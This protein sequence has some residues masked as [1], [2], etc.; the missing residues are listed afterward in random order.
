MASAAAFE[1]AL[2]GN[3]RYVDEKP[4]QKAKKGAGVARRWAV[5]K[6]GVYEPAADSVGYIF[7][8]KTEDNFTSAHFHNSCEVVVVEKGQLSVR[9]NGEEHVLSRG[10]VFFAERYV[11][12]LYK[13]VGH[14]SAYV[15]VLSDFYMS[16]LRALYEGSFPMFMFAG[17]DG[18]EP[19]VSFLQRLCG[20]WD[21]RNALM[22][23]SAAE[24]ML[25]F[26]AGRYP[27][28]CQNKGEGMLIAE[29]LR[30]I[31]ENYGENLSVASVAKKFGYS[32]NY[33]SCLFHRYT[34]V[35]F[36]RYLNRIRIQ[37]TEKL[38]EKG[39]IGVIAAAQQC[40]FVSMNT[41]YRALAEQ[42][43]VPAD[44]SVRRLES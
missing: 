24:W 2:R 11:T 19:L 1:R 33:F 36:R 12:H 18:N 29:V 7:F 44:T 20:D 15:W 26:L 21:K 25:G 39:D 40:G 41:Y 4:K 30:Y 31:D 3:R 14:S 38:L 8:D 28:V 32:P 27:P 9:G 6:N 16:G 35:N 13:S 34:D 22:R 5:M 42:E 10:D 23:R 37:K 17:E 43:K